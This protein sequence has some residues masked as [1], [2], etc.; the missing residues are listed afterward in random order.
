MQRNKYILKSSKSVI[1]FLSLCIALLFMIMQ[2]GCATLT[3]ENRER[4]ADTYQ[5]NLIEL[6]QTELTGEREVSLEDCI[7]IALRNNLKGQTAGIRA[8]IKKLERKIAFSN[9]LPALE[10]KGD[11]S[12]WEHQPM[13]KVSEGPTGPVYHA[14]HDTDITEFALEARMPI[15]APAAWYLYAV[16]KRG[17]DIGE[18]LMEY[19][20]QMITLQVTGLYY[21][22]LALEETENSLA[23]RV[24]ASE[25]LQQQMDD[26]YQEGLVS[27]WQLKQ[28]EALALARRIELNHTKRSIR[29]A[30]ADLLGS[31]GLSPLADIRLFPET[32]LDA[33]DG[34]L[35]ELVLQAL[36]NN[37]QMHI[38]D[39]TVEI[40]KDRAKIA[41]SNFLP[42]LVGFASFTSTSDSFVFDPDYW[43]SG[44]SGVLNVF[45]G[46]AN[47][48]EYKAARERE[49]EAMVQREEAC[50]AMM[51][52][53]I[54]AHL[55]LENA[56]DALALAEK[57]LTV[58]RGRLAEI[59]A[60]WQEGMVK[61]SE[62][63]S[64][65][66]EFEAADTAVTNAHFQR[67]VSI[68]TLLNVLG[69]NDE[70]RFADKNQV[71]LK[72]VPIT[73]LSETGVKGRRPIPVMQG[74]GSHKAN[75]H[76]EKERS[77]EK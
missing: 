25:T 29:E 17:E 3:K 75:V 64:A 47:I 28:V 65:I 21:Q 70:D 63:L 59:E 18:L 16:H 22:C 61:P 12:A 27:E 46:F 34:G 19:T 60:Q 72:K 5:R 48:Y 40:L 32:P 76:M 66:A 1:L 49:R 4:H 71:S 58:A 39:R 62:R 35:D 13:V 20:K 74:P 43:I 50:L 52:Q 77:N 41:I 2:A 7:Q 9:F 10:L 36:L 38:S 69:K 44:L 33:P 31:M 6:T 15:F 11:Y 67:Q 14:M 55:N 54:K 57:S 45:N 30:K 56:E 26:Y 37:P 51:L 73:R 53:V 42:N 23:S 68:A 24:A 8:R